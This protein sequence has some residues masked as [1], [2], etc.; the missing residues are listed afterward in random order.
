MQHGAHHRPL[1]T[2]VLT[3]RLMGPFLKAARWITVIALSPD[4]I[5]RAVEIVHS[6]DETSSLSPIAHA[7][8]RRSSIQPMLFTGMRLHENCTVTGAVHMI[9]V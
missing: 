9:V 8:M 1:S 3:P 4:S 5:T 6:H 7:F 2:T